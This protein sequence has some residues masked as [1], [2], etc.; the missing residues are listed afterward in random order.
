MERMKEGGREREREAGRKE[1]RNKEGKKRGSEVCC[2]D[3][4]VLCALFLLL[5]M[6]SSILFFLSSHG[7]YSIKLS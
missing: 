5:T 3:F 4:V 2:E 7:I 6:A 1:G